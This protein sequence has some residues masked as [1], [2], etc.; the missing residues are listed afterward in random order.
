MLRVEE[1]KI[2]RMLID[3]ESSADIIYLPIFQQMKLDKKW[4][5]P[6]TS[7]LVSFTRDRII[8]RGIVT[9]TVIARTYPVQVTKNTTSS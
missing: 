3:N 9:L 7:P 2:H 4:I 5:R 8:P 6:F 1:F